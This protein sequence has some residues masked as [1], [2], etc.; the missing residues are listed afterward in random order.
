MD[1]ILSTAPSSTKN[2]DRARDP[3]M[4]SSQKNNQW[5]FGMKA[6]I[7]VDANSGLVHTVRGT[8]GNVADVTEGN[9][10]LRG[11]ETEVFGDAGYQG[12]DKRADAQ[13]EV[14]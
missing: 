12:A 7:G 5:D 8:T 6:H 10:M 11:E 4:H 9:S 13:K 1:T 3:E 2:K 14:T